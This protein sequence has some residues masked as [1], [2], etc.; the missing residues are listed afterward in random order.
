MSK[1][2]CDTYSFVV[3]QLISMDLDKYGNSQNSKK[4]KMEEA[5]AARA[6]EFEGDEVSE[7]G[8]AFQTMPE[9]TYVYSFQYSDRLFKRCVADKGKVANLVRKNLEHVGITSDFK[10][11]KGSP[12]SQAR[13]TLTCVEEGFSLSFVHFRFS[14]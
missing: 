2:K 13:V 4:P 7:V 1:Y 6:P 9:T 11:V 12:R 8:I 10:L 5:L 3:K 14:N